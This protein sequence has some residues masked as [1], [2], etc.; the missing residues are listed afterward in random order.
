[1]RLELCGE[2]ARAGNVVPGWGFQALVQ[3]TVFDLGRTP[4]ATSVLLVQP[5]E[6]HGTLGMCCRTHASICVAG[7]ACFSKVQHGRDSALT[8]ARGGHAA[9]AVRAGAPRDLTSFQ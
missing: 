1:M 2:R 7:S 6:P 8:H 4:G 9:H 3:A 5:T